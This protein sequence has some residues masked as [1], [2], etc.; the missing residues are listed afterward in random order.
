MSPSGRQQID[1]RSVSV[2]AAHLNG[3]GSRMIVNGNMGELSTHSND[4][5][6]WIGCDPMARAHDA[7]KLLGVDVQ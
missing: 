1:R 3:A 5:V 4:R 2:V 7:P 6:T